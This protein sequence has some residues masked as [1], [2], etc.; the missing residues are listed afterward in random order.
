[1]ILERTPVLDDLIDSAMMK[2][3]ISISKKKEE[4]IETLRLQKLRPVR[5]H[6][7][8]NLGKRSQDLT[9]SGCISGPTISKGTYAK[10]KLIQNKKKKG[11]QSQRD[12]ME[13]YARSRQWEPNIVIKPLLGNVKWAKEGHD[14][15][16]D[17]TRKRDN[18]MEEEKEE[19][20]VTTN[21]NKSHIPS[22]SVVSTFLR[23]SS[24][25]SMKKLGASEMDE[26]SENQ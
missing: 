22:T 14:D 10:W 15:D 4:A 9:E 11:R 24:D 2:C 8:I 1:M 13:I 21:L 7:Q 17:G 12:R 18:N 5:V 26:R 16:C 23:E 6:E 3:G 25:N 19:R 20:N